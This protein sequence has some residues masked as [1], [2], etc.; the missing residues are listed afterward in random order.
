[1]IPLPSI[2]RDGTI[3]TGAAGTFLRV[4]FLTSTVEYQYRQVVTKQNS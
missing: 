1:M 2:L 3:G 4:I